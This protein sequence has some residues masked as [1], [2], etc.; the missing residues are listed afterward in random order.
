MYP[1]GTTS[2]NMILHQ[3]HERAEYSFINNC[4][5][6]RLCKSSHTALNHENAPRNQA[7]NFKNRTHIHSRS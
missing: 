1:I 6:S 4:L 2:L 7:T 3:D 5:I